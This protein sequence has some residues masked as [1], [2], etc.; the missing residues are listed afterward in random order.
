L[1]VKLCDCVC[2]VHLFSGA[3]KQVFKSS[4]APHQLHGSLSATLI[5]PSSGQSCCHMVTPLLPVRLCG[6]LACR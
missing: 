1:T 4:T 6:L 3:V 5:S 2:D